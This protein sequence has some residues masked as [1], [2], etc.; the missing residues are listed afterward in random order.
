MPKPLWAVAEFTSSREALRRQLG[1]PHHVE[2]DSTRTMGGEEDCWAFETPI[3]Q[4]VALLLRVPY[5]L[6]VIYCAPPDAREAVAALGAA[7][8][9][10][11]LRVAPVPEELV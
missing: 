1:A 11:S 2:T 4:R 6:A 9:H 10:T 5:R 3:G 8:D 7:V